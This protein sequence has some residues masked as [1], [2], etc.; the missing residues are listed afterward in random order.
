MCLKHV[1]SYRHTEPKA[2]WNRNC[3]KFI[4][5]TMVAHISSTCWF[6]I[7]TLCMYFGHRHLAPGKLVMFCIFSNCLLVSKLFQTYS[8]F[9]LHLVERS[10]NQATFPVKS[11]TNL[12]EVALQ[13]VKHMTPSILRPFLQINTPSSW[14]KWKNC[15]ALAQLVLYRQLKIHTID[16]GYHF[17]F[18]HWM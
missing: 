18:K 11:V 7:Y 9:G 6:K 5:A 1:V 13:S 10:F 4:F 14:S 3:S 8:R 2:K 17:F 12:P 15:L 16:N